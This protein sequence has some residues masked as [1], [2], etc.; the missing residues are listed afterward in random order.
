MQTS[1][2]DSSNPDARHI[3]SYYENLPSPLKDQ[4]EKLESLFKH[5]PDIRNDVK[6][7]KGRCVI[8]PT[9]GNRGMLNKN[10]T[11]SLCDPHGENIPN[12]EEIIYR[13]VILDKTDPRT[14]FTDKIS[15][16]VFCYKENGGNIFLNRP[17]MVGKDGQVYILS[18]K[19]DNG[20]EVVVKWYRSRHRD[21][22]YEIGI[23]NRLRS[24][25]AT[26]PWFS[27][28][29]QFLNTPVLVMER[30]YPLTVEDDEFEVGAVILKQ[31]MVVHKIGVHNDIKPGNIM[32][33]MDNGVPIYFLI[34]Y[35]GM[36]TE[37]YG[38][39]YR[40]GVWTYKWTC[41]IP[42]TKNQ[43]T[44]GYHDFVELLFTMRTMQNWKQNSPDQKVLCD[45]CLHRKKQLKYI[46]EKLYNI[47]CPKCKGVDDMC[48]KCS[49]KYDQLYKKYQCLNSERCKNCKKR[50]YAEI[51][52]G[53]TGKL[54]KYLTRVKKINKKHI[55]ERDYLDLIDILR[56]DDQCGSS[57]A[58]NQSSDIPD[59]GFFNSSDSKDDDD[60]S[61]VDNQSSDTS[62]G[63]SS[64][65]SDSKDNDEGFNRCWCRRCIKKYC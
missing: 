11:K 20:A 65:S 39:G 17:L 57:A 36:T 26:L 43:I 47:G 13:L 55:K 54:E 56:E 51:R 53:F 64:N 52:E 59:D 37:R 4:L 14:F 40:R 18:G 19:R 45:G 34:D 30:L 62:D 32:K 22:S 46:K 21:T 28:S 27:S 23:Y 16:P 25:K 48:N 7:L 8:T 5:N 49:K 1:P 41:Q 58:E 29:Y 15:A 60:L 38:Y 9:N 61:A 10:H 3:V 6:D 35:G 50:A 12:L 42:H 63:R 2:L 33:R 44:T 24:I 31:L